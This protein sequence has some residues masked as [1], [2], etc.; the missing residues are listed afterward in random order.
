MILLSRIVRH[1]RKQA[2]SVEY[3]VNRAATKSHVVID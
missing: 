1:F 3:D 2:S